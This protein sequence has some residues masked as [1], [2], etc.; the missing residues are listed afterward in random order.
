MAP[1]GPRKPPRAGGSGRHFHL[2]KPQL[3]CIPPA[4][5][6][7]KAHA[8]RRVICASVRQNKLF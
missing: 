4:V 3:R 5:S 2:C 6:L 7:A 1:A 8:R